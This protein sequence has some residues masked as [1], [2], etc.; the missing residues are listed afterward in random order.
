MFAEADY[1]TKRIRSKA[2]VQVQV[3][4]QG[5]EEGGFQGYDIMEDA[6]ALTKTHHYLSTYPY[7]AFYFVF[8]EKPWNALLGSLLSIQEAS[9]IALAGAKQSLLGA[10][11]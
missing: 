10:L 9:I 8:G 2:A 6:Q 5:Y 11:E 3:Q 1:S 7:I 4:V